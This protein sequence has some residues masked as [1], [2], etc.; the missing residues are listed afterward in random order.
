LPQWFLHNFIFFAEW[1]IIE[2]MEHFLPHFPFLGC[3]DGKCLGQGVN[4][5]LIEDPWCSG[6]VLIFR[7]ISVVRWYRC[8]GGP[9]PQCDFA[10]LKSPFL[11]RLLEQSELLHSVGFNIGKTKAS[12]NTR[13]A[14]QMN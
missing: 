8:C 2:K 3:F 14:R 4:R 1:R 6:D 5:C 13:Q 10:L 9:K 7:T 11:K 12:K